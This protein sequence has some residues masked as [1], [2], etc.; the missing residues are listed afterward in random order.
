MARGACHPPA[1]PDRRGVAVFSEHPGRL[2][3]K[4]EF[5]QHVWGGT[6]VTDIVLRV[7]IREI[8]AALADTAYA[9][10]ISRPVGG[11]VIGFSIAG[12]RLAPAGGGRPIVGRQPEVEAL[13]SWFARAAS[14]QRQLGFVSGEAGVGKTT[15]VDLRLSH[16][17]VMS[18]V[19]VGRG[20]CVEH[21]GGGEPYLPGLE[22]LRQLTRGPGGSAVLAALRHH[23]PMWLVQ[24]PGMVS[25]AN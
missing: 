4:T 20:Q 2:V 23:A 7:C 8:R 5:R 21:Y 1:P 22:A 6:H 3:T 16:L 9:P 11:R 12:G 19:R 17:D 15:V 10:N 24:L 25:D 14:G 13:E 18:G